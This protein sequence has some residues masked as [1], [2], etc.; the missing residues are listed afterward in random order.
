MSYHAPGLL[1]EWGE[2][3]EA[4]IAVRADAQA[5]VV[6]PS[7]VAAAPNL[8]LQIDESDRSMRDLYDGGSMGWIHRI[9]LLDL[10]MEIEPSTV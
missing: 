8:T 5:V 3:V 6:Q 2:R 4:G 9:G 10:N 7:R 1:S